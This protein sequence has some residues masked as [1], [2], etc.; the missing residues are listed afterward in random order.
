[1]TDV[2]D[3]TEHKILNGTMVLG[4]RCGRLQIKLF[5]AQDV[6][7]TYF[8]PVISNNQSIRAAVRFSLIC[9]VICLAPAPG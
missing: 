4:A 1:M 8:V 3:S 6:L 9:G 7:H 2:S 5:K